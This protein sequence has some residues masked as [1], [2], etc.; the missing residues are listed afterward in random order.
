[1]RRLADGYL[2][3]GGQIVIGDIGFPNAA[4]RDEVKQRMGEWWED[5]Y[6]W[7]ADETAAALKDA[8]FMMH[9]EQLSSC[10]V[11]ISLQPELS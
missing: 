7:I 4:A 2:R 9:Y 10:G 6:Y 5:E 1:L 8:G 3:P 11:V